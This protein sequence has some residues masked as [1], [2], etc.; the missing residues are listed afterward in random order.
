MGGKSKN[1]TAL[2][3]DPKLDFPLIKFKRNNNK[4]QPSIQVSATQFSPPSEE[5]H[6]KEI[7]IADNGNDNRRTLEDYV[8]PR[9]RGNTSSI[10][11]PPVQAHNVE[12]KPIMLQ[13]VQ[14]EQFMGLPYEDPH[15]HI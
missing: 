15:T 10:V 14:Q 4:G 11:R 2:V 9:L 1:K 5:K 3:F 8:I 13:V 7:I 6:K 12:V